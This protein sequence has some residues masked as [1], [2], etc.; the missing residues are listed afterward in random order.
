MS[1]RVGTKATSVYLSP[2]A[3]KVLDQYVK[4]SDYGSASR[5]IEEI[6]L[7]Y[8][9]IY[10]SIM[11]FFFTGDGL[12]ALKNPVAVY[13]VFMNL[14]NFFTVSSGSPYEKA[15]QEKIAKQLKDMAEGRDSL[16]IGTG[17]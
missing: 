9:T 16:G 15:V 17:K 7:A 5:T 10:N 2:R 13:I 11:G 6:I 12:K 3:Q 14:L 8:D 1:E 4:N